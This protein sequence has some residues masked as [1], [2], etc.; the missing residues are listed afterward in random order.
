M[1]EPTSNVPIPPVHC[2]TDV[3]YRIGNQVHDHEARIRLLE[4]DTVMLLESTKRLTDSVGN[5]REAQEKAQLRTEEKLDGIDARLSAHVIAETGSVRRLFSSSILQ[6]LVVV[7][8]LLY[9]I[10]ETRL[11]G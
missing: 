2:G 10:F 8:G 5:L 6:F 1:D 4:R 7:S 9:L 11:A 3:Y